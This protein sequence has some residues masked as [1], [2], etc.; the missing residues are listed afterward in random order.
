M[1]PQDADEVGHAGAVSAIQRSHLVG[2][3][4]GLFTLPDPPKQID[5]PLHLPENPVAE[6][7]I[8]HP[9]NTLPARGSSGFPDLFLLDPGRIARRAQQQAR[10]SEPTLI[11]V[12]MT[13]GPGWQI[14]GPMSNVVFRCPR[15][16]LNVQHWLAEEVS[17]GDPQCTYEAVVCKACTRLHFIN[18]ATGKLLGEP[19][20]PAAN[21]GQAE[22]AGPARPRGRRGV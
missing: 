15:T 11:K 12:N 5:D 19:E 13:A 3:C 4:S 22:P 6:G 2:I 14:A 21:S 8:T 1:H 17:P 16:G 9:A 18:R 10:F 20:S 7:L